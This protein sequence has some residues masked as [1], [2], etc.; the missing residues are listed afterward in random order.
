MSAAPG[1]QAAQPTCLLGIRYVSPVAAHPAPLGLQDACEILLCLRLRA[2]RVAGSP[3]SGSRLEIHFEI[4]FGLAGTLRFSRVAVGGI[5]PPGP[6]QIGCQRSR[7]GV[8]VGPGVKA[9]N[10]IGDQS[11][12]RPGHAHTFHSIVDNV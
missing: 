10:G 9:R 12:G 7:V 5:T 11:S 4:V 2:L 8:L 3:P 1:R 6:P